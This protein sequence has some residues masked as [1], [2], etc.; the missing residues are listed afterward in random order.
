L[1]AVRTIPESTAL[2]AKEQHDSRVHLMACGWI[3]NDP[4][5][6]RIGVERPQCPFWVILRYEQ[7]MR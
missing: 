3:F 6:D 4:V 7:A 5:F 1:V 2:A